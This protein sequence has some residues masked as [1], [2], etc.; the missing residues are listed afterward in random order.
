VGAHR[1]RNPVRGD[2]DRALNPPGKGN[3][4]DFGSGDSEG[5]L[6]HHAPFNFI[7]QLSLFSQ[8][9]SL[10]KPMIND[11]KHMLKISKIND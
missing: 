4:T 8:H 9:R 10:H 5:P 3:K 7:S 6:T 2:G 1:N 11:T